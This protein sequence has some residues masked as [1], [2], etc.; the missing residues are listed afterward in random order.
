MI[1]NTMESPRGKDGLQHSLS[2][3]CG[4][5]PRGGKM[6]RWET[7][8]KVVISTMRLAADLVNTEIEEEEEEDKDQKCSS[9]TGRHKTA[10]QLY[11]VLRSVRKC[12]DS[13]TKQFS[14]YV[15]L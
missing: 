15:C 6:K 7:L 4:K 13:L 11:L 10:Q 3:Q 12:R 1:H 14:T 9:L 2:E 8:K 5:R